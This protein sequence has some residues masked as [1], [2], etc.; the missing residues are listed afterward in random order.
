MPPGLLGMAMALSRQNVPQ[1]SCWPGAPHWGTSM[2]AIFCVMWHVRAVALGLHHPSTS[3]GDLGSCN[4]GGFFFPDRGIPS[5]SC[6]LLALSG[7]RKARGT[8]C[9]N[10]PAAALPQLP[11][12][13]GVW[14]GTW[15]W[16]GRREVGHFL[17]ESRTFPQAESVLRKCAGQTFLLWGGK[18]DSKENEG[19]SCWY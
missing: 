5:Q 6:S 10:L 15:G 13:R 4:Q 12:G 11:V 3:V 7:R 19:K 1:P 18:S 14:V 8:S 2:L 17:W 9:R 16:G